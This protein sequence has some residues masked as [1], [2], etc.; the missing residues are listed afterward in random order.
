MHTPIL[1]SAMVVDPLGSAHTTIRY[2]PS[3]RTGPVKTAAGEVACHWVIEGCGMQQGS[4][5]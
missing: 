4:G 3:E 1:T 2:L 5:T